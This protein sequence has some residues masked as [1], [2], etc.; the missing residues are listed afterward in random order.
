MR[1]KP[2]SRCSSLLSVRAAAERN[3]GRGMHCR[4]D[5]CSETSHQQ[6]FPRQGIVCHSSLRIFIFLTMR[7]GRGATRLM[8][9]SLNVDAQMDSSAWLYCMHFLTL[10]L[11]YLRR[12]QNSRNSIG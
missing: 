1:L 4:R 5:G 8:M 11:S 6:Q 9:H 3:R 12:T 2:L 7:A 10:N